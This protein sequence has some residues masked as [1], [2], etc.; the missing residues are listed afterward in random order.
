MNRIMAGILV[1]FASIMFAGNARAQFVVT[2][3]GNLTQN[4]LDAIAS[5]AMAADMLAMLAMMTAAA[6]I[7]NLNDRQDYPTQT[8]LNNQL[9][10]AKTPASPMATGIVTDEDRRVTGTDASGEL[11]KEQ[12]TSA[13]NCAA[14]AAGNLDALESIRQD[15][16]ELLATLKEAMDYAAEKARDTEKAVIDLNK[17]INFLALCDAANAVAARTDAANLRIQRMRTAAIFA[18][19]RP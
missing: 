19:T 8:Q 13:A 2:D 18:T 1:L 15:G 6:S 16:P 14:I 5:A 12:I 11:L 9:F 3:P 10:D 4:T 7:S 17:A